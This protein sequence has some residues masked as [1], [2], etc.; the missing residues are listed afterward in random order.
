VLRRP[1]E[2]AAFAAF[3][4]YFPM[5]RCG[6]SMETFAAT[7]KFSDRQIHIL[8]TKQNFPA[9][10]R[11][12]AF[13]R[14]SFLLTVMMLKKYFNSCFVALT[15]MQEFDVMSQMSI[16]AALQHCTCSIAVP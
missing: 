12:S 11:I 3:H 14:I 16:H 5:L 8:R 9:L 15:S 1:V 4:R 10:H 6:P 7:A 13:G 2:V